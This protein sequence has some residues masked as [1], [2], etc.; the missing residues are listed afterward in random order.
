M[1]LT[2]VELRHIVHD[3]IAAAGPSGISEPDLLDALADRYTPNTLQPLLDDLQSCGFALELVTDDD[4]TRRWRLASATAATLDKPLT[5]RHLDH[6]E[7]HG[8]DADLG[9]RIK[10]AIAALD[11]AARKALASTGLPPEGAR[12]MSAMLGFDADPLIVARLGLC[13]R[14]KSVRILYESPFQDPCVPTWHDVEPWAVHLDPD[15]HYLRAW[16]I[17]EQ[18]PCTFDLSYIRALEDLDVAPPRRRVSAI[19]WFDDS[20]E[21]AGPDA[22]RPGLATFRVRGDAAR[23]I[24][25]A[26]WHPNQRDIWKK[27]GEL[28]ER[29]V[30]YHNIREMAGRLAKLSDV[31]HIAPPELKAEVLALAPEAAKPTR[32]KTRKRS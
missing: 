26:R 17:A 7:E 3:I 30:P 32:K 14:R 20:L 12:A 10:D 6:L 19:P 29:R 8:I 25:R 22:D 5:L 21:G 9:A 1:P 11:D 28:L 16:S 13:C 4:G 15:A 27:P 2:R 24:A 31:S 18:Q 23:S